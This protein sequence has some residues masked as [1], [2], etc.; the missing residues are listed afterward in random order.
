MRL[1]KILAIAA[2]SAIA[3]SAFAQYDIPSAQAN[4]GASDQVIPFLIVMNVPE[5][6]PAAPVNGGG[7]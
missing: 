2:L 4:S 3:V 1:N 7:S 5:D 6:A